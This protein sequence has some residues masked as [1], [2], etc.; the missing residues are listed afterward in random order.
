MPSRSPIWPTLP[1][2]D[3]FAQALFDSSADL[4]LPEAPGNL[5][6][7]PQKIHLDPAQGGDWK[8]ELTEQVPAEQLPAETAQIKFVKIQSKLLSEFYGRPI[9]LRAGIVLPRDYERDPSR[10][11]PLWVRIGGLNTRYTE[12]A[13]LDGRKVRVRGRPGRP[14]T[15]RD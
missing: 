15:R 5:Y 4:R 10:R 2:G 6:S 12:R 11:Y 9:F 1:A 13:R 7:K 8:L 14:T 3:Y